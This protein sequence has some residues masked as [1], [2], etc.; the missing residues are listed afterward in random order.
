MRNVPQN[1]TTDTAPPIL[2]PILPP[3]IGLAGVSG[4]GKT[5]LGLRLVTALSAAGREAWSLSFARAVRDVVCV[6]YPGLEVERK[7]LSAEARERLQEVGSALRGVDPDVFVRR[8]EGRL[9]ELLTAHPM[10]AATV[11]LDD[12]R[13]PNE[14]AWIRGRG[15]VVMKLETPGVK[16]VLWHDSERAAQELEGD[17]GIETHRLEDAAADKEAVFRQ[18]CAHLA[19]WPRMSAD[20]GNGADVFPN[21]GVV[22]LAGAITGK[23]YREAAA[24]RA[25]VTKRLERRGWAVRNPLAQR[26][27]ASDTPA[28]RIFSS[29]EF[30]QEMARHDVAD[31]FD[32]DV[33][34]VNP[35]GFEGSIGTQL[36]VALARHLNKHVLWLDAL[37]LQTLCYEGDEE[38]A[39]GESG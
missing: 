29:A 3:I 28:G 2:P 26:A 4:V 13:Y 31:I 20:V 37:A 39:P 19:M 12:V 15:G 35:N 21:R 14:A 22:Y 25:R 10:C 24:W 23:T 34:L 16:P 33:V 36:E 18:L 30:T 5:T 11:I 27:P 6:L 7:P 38:G 1:A 8:C 32:A 9:Q 17:Y